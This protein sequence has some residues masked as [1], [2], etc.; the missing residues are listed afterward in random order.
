MLF[1]TQLSLFCNKDDDTYRVW[2]PVQT[3]EQHAPAFLISPW[4]GKDHQVWKTAAEP[5][6]RVF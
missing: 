4:L 3:V 6:F 2:L 5:Q 1:S